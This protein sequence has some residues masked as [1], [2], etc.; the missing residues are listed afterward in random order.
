VINPEGGSPIPLLDGAQPTPSRDGSRIAYVQHWSTI[1]SSTPSGDDFKVHVD[2]QAGSVIDP[3][4][5]PDGRSLLF[6]RSAPLGEP[7]TTRIFIVT[8]DGSFRQFIPE[9]Q[10][11][12]SP[13][14]SDW[15]PD[16]SW[17]D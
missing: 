10:N 12:T 4:W 5:S 15:N 8:G 7:G 13:Y 1:V 3:A 9:A 14:Y 16:W 2:Y 6:T 17:A 11:P